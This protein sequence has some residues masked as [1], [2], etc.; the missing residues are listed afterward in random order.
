MAMQ[1][2]CPAIATRQGSRFRWIEPTVIGKNR[3]S[4][5]GPSNS[6][7]PSFTVPERIVPPT[8]VPTAAIEYTSSIY[9]RLIDWSLTTLSA[10]IGYIVP[11]ISM[12]QLKK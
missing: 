12:L 2:A 6:P 8:T 1:A 7:S 10:Q 4:S 3:P 5:D 9:N 11:L